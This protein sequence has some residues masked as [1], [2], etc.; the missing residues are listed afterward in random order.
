MS[1]KYSNA[2]DEVTDADKKAD[3]AKKKLKRQSELE[4]LRYLLQS[5]QGR[6][7]FWRLLSHCSVYN[8][9]FNTN[10][11]TQSHNSGRQDIGHF[12]QGEIV[13][14]SPDNYLKMQNEQQIKETKV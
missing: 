3:D 9:I 7:F 4:D 5:Q 10:A 11:L 13:Q 14:A 2:L 12:V 8:S 6:R 1:E